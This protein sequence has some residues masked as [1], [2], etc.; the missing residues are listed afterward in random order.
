MTILNPEETLFAQEI[1]HGTVYLSLLDRLQE[2]LVREFSTGEV[3]IPIRDLTPDQQSLLQ[4]NEF[5]T[6]LQV[7]FEQHHWLIT[8]SD[9]VIRV[10]PLPVFETVGITK[11]PK[12]RTAKF[13]LWLK[14]VLFG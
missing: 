6:C 7:E 10:M 14:G 8:I 3:C 13:I 12:T 11:E 2:K 9:D 1:H 4:R 5:R